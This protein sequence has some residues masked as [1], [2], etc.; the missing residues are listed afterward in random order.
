[1][2]WMGNGQSSESLVITPYGVCLWR[3]IRNLGAKFMSK[4]SHQVG[5]GLKT[6]FWS[7]SWLGQH[8]LKQFFPII[9]SLNN[10]KLPW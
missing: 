6:S 2:K 9:F 7:D 10:N 8:P 1:M 5:N 3:S 4:C